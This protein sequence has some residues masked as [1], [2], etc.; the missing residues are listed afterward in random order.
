MIKYVRGKS[1]HT[2]AGILYGLTD[3]SDMFE[4]SEKA[5]VTILFDEVRKFR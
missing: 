5:E 3:D 4:P 1:S 2:L